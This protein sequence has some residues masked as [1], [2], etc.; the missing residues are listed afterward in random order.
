MLIAVSKE[1]LI[2][3]LE[4]QAHMWNGVTD[5][6]NPKAYFFDPKKVDPND[7]EEKGYYDDKLAWLAG[8]SIKEVANMI[9][10]IK[11]APVLLKK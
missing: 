10:V 11:N 1:D 2:E 9:Q 3:F 8:A 5:R 7:I 6:P 4:N